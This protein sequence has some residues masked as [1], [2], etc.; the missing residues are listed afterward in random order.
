MLSPHE[1]ATLLFVQDAPDQLHMMCVQLETLQEL[2]L[3]E[4]EEPTS[5]H[6][7]WRLTQAGHSVLRVIQQ[8]A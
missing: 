2:H 8:P 5:G 6:Q 7:R 4:P 3:V 1:F